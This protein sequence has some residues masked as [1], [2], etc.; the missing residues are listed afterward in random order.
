MT[1]PVKVEA[2]KL[3]DENG[4]TIMFSN[5]TVMESMN[6]WFENATVQTIEIPKETS[7]SL[8][9]DGSYAY[10]SLKDGE[11]LSFVFK[12]QA[13]VPTRFR[14]KYETVPYT[15]TG[16]ALIPT[17]SALTESHTRGILRDV[18]ITSVIAVLPLTVIILLSSN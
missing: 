9:E 5:R 13:R 2:L 14:K 4:Q 11:K 1:T 7:F 18:T 10:L 3:I 6:N 15:P 17:L 16:E 12:F 8:E